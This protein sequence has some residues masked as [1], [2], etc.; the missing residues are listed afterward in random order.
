MSELFS[1]PYFGVALSVAAFGIGVKLQQKLKTPVCNPLIAAI[2]LIAGVL[3]IFKIPYEAYNA[4]GEIINMFLAPATSCLA[5]AIYA[6]IK[7]LKQYWLPI[8]VGCTM[9]SAAS[10]LSVYGLC[11]L[12]GLDESLT[13]SL[14]PKSV[15][16]PVAVS[17]AEP[18][19]GVVPITVVAVIGTGILG[20]MI[21][22]LLIRIFKVTEPMAAGLAIGASSHAVGTSKA[23]ELGEVEGA[24]SGLAIGV[25]G[26]ITVLISMV[27]L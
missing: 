16:T 8:L 12:F 21:A 25:C 17:I 11:R 22:P 13:V 23:V 1:S 3:L 7:I 18:A 26:I 20:S 6:K 10:M 2:V 15:T 19:G 5:V 24:M 27:V 9:G 14:L 4:G